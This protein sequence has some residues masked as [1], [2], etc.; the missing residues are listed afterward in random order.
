MK[1]KDAANLL[2]PEQHQNARERA[3]WELYTN[4]RFLYGNRLF[5]TLEDF[6]AWM[7]KQV[8]Q[9]IQQ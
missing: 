7:D 4:A 3:Y 5:G 8:D 9:L 1:T 6:T 2:Y